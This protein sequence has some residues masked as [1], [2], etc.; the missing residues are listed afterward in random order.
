MCAYSS[1]VIG[2][3]LKED[4]NSKSYQDI[5][6]QAFGTKGRIIASTFI[7]LEIFFALVSYTI[8]L[9]DNLALALSGAHIH[10]PWLNLSTPQILM[11]IAVTLAL[12]SLWLRDLSSISFLSFVGILMS[13]LIFGT[14]L[15]TAVFGG[16]RCDQSIPVLVMRK[17]P[18]ISGLYMFGYAGHIVFPNIYKA[19]KDPSK[20]TKVSPTL[21]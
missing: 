10:L 2:K 4:S 19:M 12:P 3:C 15:W 5:G 1:H 8:S 9:N 6:E 11:V 17:I 21:S 16:I 14:V 7:Y 18:G 13:L 20:F